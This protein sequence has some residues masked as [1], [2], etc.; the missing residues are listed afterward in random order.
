M[1]PLNKFKY[2]LKYGIK[3]RLGT[4]AFLISNIVIFI[5]LLGILNLPNI[6]A[7]FDNNEGT[8]LKVS[9]Y[10]ETNK[11]IDTIS[12]LNQYG[13]TFV[14]MLPNTTIEFIEVETFDKEAI[15]FNGA[16][17]VV[18][19]TMS[20]D[21]LKADIYKDELEVLQENIIV[22][23]LSQ[24][25]INVWSIDKTDAE[26]ALVDDFL[27]PLNYQIISEEKDTA[28]R[29][30]ILSVISMFIA[31]P[32]F[33]MLIMSVQF[34]GIDII[35]EK[36]TKAIE[37]VM[38][39][40]PPQTH[41]MTKIL[42][43]FAFLVTQSLLIVLYGLIAGFI[44]TKILGAS[45]TGMSV[46]EIIGQFTETDATIIKDVLKALPMALTWTLLF[47]IIG[48]LFYMIFMATLASMS[49]S[50]EDFQS[51][52][53]P[54]MFMM[55][56]GF[57]ASIFSVYMGDSIVLKV[58]GYIPLFAPIVAPTLFMSGVFSV[59]DTIIVFVLLL[60][61]TVA[62]YYFLTPIYKASILSYDESGF[63]KRISKMFKRSKEA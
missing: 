31:I 58:I 59:V 36:S 2:L 35:E 21:L 54:F 60:G 7:F 25:R 29:D 63:F 8:T 62:I 15:E 61:S 1:K 17:A 22:Q 26:K 20:D 38:S 19:L 16:N 37:Y 13:D 24:Y 11:S 30:L 3:K 5:A 45:G 55:M 53:S 10:D 18:H 57:Y 34:V 4:K 49:T 50:M 6:I 9:V 52:Q 56:I 43:S 12:I 39:T 48:G 33:I 23:I 46:T 28:T 32:I 42:S 14:S 41:F 47:T 44:S 51:F 27:A 40:V